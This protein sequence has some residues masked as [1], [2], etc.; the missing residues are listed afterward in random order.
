MHDYRQL[1]QRT[2]KN[3]FPLPPIKKC[4]DALTGP[5]GFLPWT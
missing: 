2:R 3:A 5:A 4:L 1:N